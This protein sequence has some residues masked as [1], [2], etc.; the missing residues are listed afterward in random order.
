MSGLK[1]A[2][3]AMVLTLFLSGCATGGPSAE[4]TDPSDIVDAQTR[5]PEWTALPHPT[6]SAV[7]SIEQLLQD[8][9]WTSIRPEGFEEKCDQ[10]ISELRTHA[11]NE[12]EFKAGLKE[13]INKHVTYYHY[14]FYEKLNALEI[15]LK[16]EDYIED[17]QAVV[18]KTYRTL[19]PL[20]R[21]FMENWRESRYLR[22]ASERYQKLSPRVFFRKVEPSA[23]TTRQLVDLQG[24]QEQQE[25]ALES[26]SSVVEKLK[27]TE[28]AGLVAAPTTDLDV[29]SSTENSRTPASSEMLSPSS[30]ADYPALEQ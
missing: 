3:T 14:C 12:A 2:T 30:S 17:R 5:A 21:A 27:V 16:T 13:L 8:R 9:V 24:T 4:E 1:A 23:E 15:R 25:R 7:G 28:P 29:E 18:L 20:A 19:T 11:S 6:S 10:A 26:P 22:V